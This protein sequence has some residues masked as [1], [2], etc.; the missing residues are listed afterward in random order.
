MTR[1]EE[2]RLNEFGA[3]V[4]T[5]I[6][7]YRQLQEDVSTLQQRVAQA[8]QAAVA[9]KADA[10]QAREEFERLKVARMMSIADGDIQEARARIDKLVRRVDKCIAL[11]G[12]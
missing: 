7:K 6:M 11:L 12:A 9:A 3:R 8:E 5:L 4:R 10:A 1:D 2:Q